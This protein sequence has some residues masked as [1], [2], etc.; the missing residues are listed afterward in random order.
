MSAQLA[1]SDAAASERG[2][3][4]YIDFKEPRWVPG[5]MFLVDVAAIESALLFGYLARYALRC[6]P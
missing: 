6:L 2:R 5:F 4:R 3:V 1:L